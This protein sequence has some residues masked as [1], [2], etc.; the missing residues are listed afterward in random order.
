MTI[1]EKIKELIEENAEELNRHEYQ[2]IKIIVTDSKADYLTFMPSRKKKKEL[3][4]KD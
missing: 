3:N 2:T 4:S 1:A